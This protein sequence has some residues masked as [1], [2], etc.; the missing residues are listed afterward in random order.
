MRVQVNPATVDQPRIE[1]LEPK[2]PRSVS[3]LAEAVALDQAGHPLAAA[4]LLRSALE[5][6]VVLLCE[7]HG[8]TPPRPLPKPIA[9]RKSQQA[10]KRARTTS[11]RPILQHCLEALYTE[12]ILN[13]TTANRVTRTTARLSPAAHGRPVTPAKLA[14]VFR[15]AQEF[16]HG[17]PAAP[18]VAPQ[19][20]TA[21]PADTQARRSGRVVPAEVHAEWG[22]AGPRSRIKEFSSQDSGTQGP[23]AAGATP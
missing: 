16:I 2:P 17:Q 4:C 21:L 23:D 1:I 19:A 6:R 8:C 22:L 11:T 14:A 15:F 9:A 20:G 3:L 5:S 12:G 13:R 18:I 10:R 7:R